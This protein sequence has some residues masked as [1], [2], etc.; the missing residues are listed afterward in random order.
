M[1]R[2]AAGIVSAALLLIA[3]VVPS[4]GVVGQDRKGSTLQPKWQYKIQ[5]RVYLGSPSGWHSSLPWLVSSPAIGN[6][7]YGTEDLEIVTGTEEGYFEWFPNGADSGRYIALDSHG[8]HLW[9]YRTQNNAGRAAPALAD[10]DGDGALECIGGSTSG[11][12]VHLFDGK[13]ARRWRYEVANQAN[14]LAP[15]A[16]GELTDHPGLEVV[17]VTLDAAIYCM[18]CDGKPLWKTPSPGRF[19]HGAA[20]GAAI[21]D[22]DGDG[23]ADVV[24]T[25]PGA[26][27]RTLCL[28]G[29]SGKVKWASVSERV[30]AEVTMAAPAILPKADPC[31]KQAA[32]GREGG[33]TRIITGAG[34][35]LRCLSGADGRVLWTYT[36]TGMIASSPAIGDV[37]GDGAPEVVFGDGRGLTCL[38]AFNGKKEWRF[39]TQGNVY[40]SP[41][42][43]DRSS[44]GARRLEWPMARHDAART[45]FY[46]YQRGPLAVYFGA[47]DGYLR[48]VDGRTGTEIDSMFIKFPDLVIQ[49]GNH[50]ALP[51]MSSPAVADIDGNGTL[52]IAFTLVD[53]VWCIEDKMS[54]V[55]RYKQPLPPSNLTVEGTKRN[56]APS[57]NNFALAQVIHPGGWNPTVPVHQKLLDELTKRANLT[58]M[59]EMAPVSLRDDDITRYPFL[60]VTGHEAAV[61]IDSEIARLKG[62]LER[63]GFMFAEACCNAEGFEK[64]IRLLAEKL[65]MGTFDRIPNDHP[66]I[67]RVYDMRT[68][69]LKGKKVAPEFWALKRNDRIVLLFTNHDHGCSWGNPCCTSGCSGVA[70]EDSY[71]MMTNIVAYALLE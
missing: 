12:M 58:V 69:T 15:P 61:F 5:E 47:D 56:T 63:G 71:R 36:S 27:V 42:L 22:V 8:R 40:C 48:V 24:A 7:G 66:I 68:I 6:L 70:S 33:E 30:N 9:T 25:L 32:L 18:T 59:N 10:I 60:Y 67:T 20:A 13:G 38:N 16:V 2:R 55:P 19:K 44:S 31:W 23:K 39:E 45:G 41:A 26:P 49:S 62:H 37:D 17:A 54:N 51:F 29:A 46:G 28:D 57:K 21:A 11:W 50:G 53:R 34:N 65:A 64:S 1:R 4:T 43:A 35:E 52:E 14:V 3:L